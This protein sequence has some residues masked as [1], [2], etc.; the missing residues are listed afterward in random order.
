MQPLSLR[1]LGEFGLIHRFSG[2][3]ATREGVRLGIGDDAAVLDALRQPIVTVDALVEGVHYRRDWMSAEALGYKAMAVNVSDVAAMG[4]RPVAAFIALAVS[5]EDDVEFLDGLYRGFEQAAARFG[6]TVAGGDTVRANGPGM[7]S[8]TVIG[9]CLNPERG[10]VLRSG[11]QDGDVLLVSGTL[12]DSAAGLHLLLHP[13]IEMAFEE[14]AT[15]IQ[16]HLVPEPRLAEMECLLKTQ[17]KAVHAALDLSDGLA[18]DARHMAKRSGLSLEIEVERLPISPQVLVLAEATGKDPVAWAL[19][20]GE[21]YE[22][23]LAV[24]PAAVDLLTE[25]VLAVT[26]TRLTAI[27]RCL[28]GPPEVRVLEQGRERQTRSGFTHF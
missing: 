3:L 2:A 4:A 7:I 23:L 10:P 15:L 21:D 8:V 17:P 22:L 14:R 20:G 9:E 19:S 11:A 1:D 5:A 13:E 12:G 6:F 16:R 25:T 27:G 28:S 26:G 24:E 18:G